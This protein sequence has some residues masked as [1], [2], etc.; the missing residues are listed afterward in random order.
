MRTSRRLQLGSNP[1]CSECPY[2]AVVLRG[3]GDGCLLA[4][5]LGLTVQQSGP[6]TDILLI[7]S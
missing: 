4:V 1:E 3:E 6:A 7:S 2:Q 5:K